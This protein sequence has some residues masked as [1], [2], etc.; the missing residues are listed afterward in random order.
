MWDLY[1]RDHQILFDLVEKTDENLYKNLLKGDDEAYARLILPQVKK[2]TEKTNAMAKAYYDSIVS[3]YARHDPLNK[4]KVAEFLGISDNSL[5]I[6]N[7]FI[8]NFQ[9][10][11]G[12]H[13]KA[14][15]QAIESWY[16]QQTEWGADSLIE[17]YKVYGMESNP[18]S[19]AYSLND[20]NGR[21]KRS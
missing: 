19:I 7:C 21:L 6:Y 11:T 16:G 3:S 5:I 2:Y 17:T 14:L 4:R 15:K 12:E 13:Q 18:S 10:P 1:N 8:K 20:F 9:G